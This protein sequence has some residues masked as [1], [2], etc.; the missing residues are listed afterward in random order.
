M[1]ASNEVPL[2]AAISDTACSRVNDFNPARCPFGA[3]T[4]AATFC[5]TKPSRSASRMARTSTLCAICTVRVDSLPARA[6]SAR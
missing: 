6:V 3:S 4:S 1:Y 2:A 5:P